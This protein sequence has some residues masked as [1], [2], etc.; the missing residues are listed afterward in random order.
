MSTKPA[1]TALQTKAIA[2]L[3]DG[4]PKAA[5]GRNIPIIAKYGTTETQGTFATPWPIE[6]TG[7]I[8]LPFAG[9]TVKLVP[10]AD[11]LEIRVKGL[12]VTPGYTGDLAA[13][14][15]AFDD[16]GFYCTGDG[17]KLIDPAKPELGVVFDGRLSENFKLQSGTWVDVGNARMALIAALDPLLMDAVI[18]GEGEADVRALGWLRIAEAQ[19]CAGAALTPEHLVHHRAIRAHCASALTCCNAAAGG[20]SR[21]IAALRLLI[22]PPEGDEIADKGYINQREVIRQ[23]ADD[24]AALY[25]GEAILSLEQAEAECGS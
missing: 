21:R 3:A 5:T 2:L 19:T 18:V 16:E 23:R 24:V 7:P 17:A 14:T 25:R 4:M 8:G 6:Q 1:L 10:V 12:T 15:A 11:S 13:S 22:A 20:Q 9:N